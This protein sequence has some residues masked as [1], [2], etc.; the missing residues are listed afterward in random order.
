[1]S[2][3]DPMPVFVLKAKDELAL[4]AIL[5]YR[6]ACLDAGLYRQAEQVALAI[7]EIA[8][9]R[10][11]NA[12]QVKAPDHDHVP[13]GAH[14]RDYARDENAD[15]E[16]KVDIVED[17]QLR[18]EQH[19]TRGKSGDEGEKR[20]FGVDSADATTTV[21]SGTVSPDGTVTIDAEH[22]GYADTVR[23]LFPITV[24]T[25]WLDRCTCSP[26]DAAMATGPLADI[27]CPVLKPIVDAFGVG[28]STII[29][30]RWIHQPNRPEVMRGRWVETRA[31]KPRAKAGK[32]TDLLAEIRRLQDEVGVFAHRSTMN[33]GRAITAEQRAREATDHAR[34]M[35]AETEKLRAARSRLRNLAEQRAE[36]ISDLRNDLKVAS[37]HSAEKDGVI[38]A[39][40]EQVRAMQPAQDEIVDLRRILREREQRIEALR[41][42][43][44][45]ITGRD[46]ALI[47][48]L[49]TEPTGGRLVSA[50]EAVQQ[51]GWTKAEDKAPGECICSDG[52]WTTPDPGCPIHGLED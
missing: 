12:G 28:W 33:L 4:M 52:A 1:M 36:T 9:W 7:S 38:E 17:A 39:L 10:E 24:A 8:Q 13:T 48:P 18:T 3:T 22:S 21:V 34:V 2:D 50:E 35:A 29:D 14:K 32:V 44:A 26:D 49:K 43:I 19:V 6:R 45:Q 20:I 41:K 47:L 25:D 37:R 46:T 51:M 27:N 5:A 30:G 23:K 11:R 15:D 42:H 40:R 31:M 16:G